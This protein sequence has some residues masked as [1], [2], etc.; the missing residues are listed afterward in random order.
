MNEKLRVPLFLCAHLAVR[1]ENIRPVVVL[2][3]LIARDFLS[4]LMMEVVLSLL[5]A[6]PL[7]SEL[8]LVLL[9]SRQCQ[10]TR[11]VLA[12]SSAKPSWVAR[13]GTGTRLL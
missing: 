10:G 11:R 4:V 9:R 1:V 6:V 5:L 8:E 12:Q 3:A 13:D 7:L 2:V